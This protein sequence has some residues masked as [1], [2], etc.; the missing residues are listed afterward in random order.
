MQMILFSTIETADQY[1]YSRGR[2]F[3][4]RFV[5]TISQQFKQWSEH[6]V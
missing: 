1:D 6:T 4:E 3:G 5:T 2:H